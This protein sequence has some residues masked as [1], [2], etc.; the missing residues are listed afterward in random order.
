MPSVF[1]VLLVG[2]LLMTIASVV[3]AAIATVAILLVAACSCVVLMAI[4]AM[5]AAADVTHAMVA[6]WSV[7]ISMRML[8]KL[9]LSVRA[10]QKDLDTAS[11]LTEN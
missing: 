6:T 10:G 11:G 3:M 7:A 1:L 2:F 5:A 4:A 9:S 8:L